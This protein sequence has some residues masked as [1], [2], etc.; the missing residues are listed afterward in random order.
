MNLIVDK[1]SMKFAR[2]KTWES[3]GLVISNYSHNVAFT[4][5]EQQYITMNSQLHRMQM[6]LSLFILKSMAR[7]AH[8]KEQEENNALG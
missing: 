5:L 1:L 6:A 8:F 3:S 2:M 4:I 7:H